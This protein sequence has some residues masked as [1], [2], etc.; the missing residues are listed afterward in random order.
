MVHRAASGLIAVMLC[1]GCAPQAGPSR[2]T[3]TASPMSSAS[4]LAGGCGTTSIHQGPAPS[5]FRPQGAPDNLPYA[6]ASPET[7][8]ADLWAFPLRAGHPLGPAN[9][10][11]WVLK[12]TFSETL[13][14]T[15]HPTAAEA[16]LI[17]DSL[18]PA[19]H[20]YPSIEDVPTPGCWRF[21]LITSGQHW[22]IDLAYI[23]P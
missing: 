3:V 18:A 23:Q 9:K 14:L 4:E 22:T 16:P 17:T 2:P 5:W 6:L 19:G 8:A 7:A 21:E 11:M 10:I 13:Q 20:V 15:I 12:G 1:I